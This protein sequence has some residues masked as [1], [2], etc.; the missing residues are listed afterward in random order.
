[1]LCTFPKP[2]DL[3]EI[4]FTL[5]GEN[6]CACVNILHESLSIYRWKGEIVTNKEVLCL[7]KTTRARHA[8]LVARLAELHP[9][10]VPE[11]VTL[12]TSAVNEPYLRWV[13]D[14]TAPREPGAAAGRDSRER[15]ETDDL[16][17]DE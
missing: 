8:E 6:L 15:G 9:Y 7:I 5:V 11:I 3:G 17:D 12:P 14:E 16:E 10:D 13:R 2:E 4:A 1:M